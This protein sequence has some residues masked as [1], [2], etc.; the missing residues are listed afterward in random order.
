M[1]LLTTR[2]VEQWQ[3]KYFDYLSS[4]ELVIE[5]SVVEEWKAVGKELMD[6]IL[7]R[8]EHQIDV[9]RHSAK[10][11]FYWYIRSRILLK[12]KR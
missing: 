8:L 2:L 3:R 12:G 6:I 1:A 10:E 4:P 7:D 5:P 9:V 11:A